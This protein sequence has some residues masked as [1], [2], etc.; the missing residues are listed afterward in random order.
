M[1]VY[2][3]NPG[4][5]GGK[6]IK[7]VK[8]A[9]RIDTTNA[10]TLETRLCDELKELPDMLQFD[11]SDLDY[12]TSAGLRVILTVYKKIT[13][14]GKEMEI[15]HVNDSIWNVFKM[16]GFLETMTIKKGN[17]DEE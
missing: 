13:A 5:P 1:T 15:L 4:E 7:A 10:F 12:L 11:F 3:E 17:K 14:A 8:V 2:T 9:G 16:T 6:K